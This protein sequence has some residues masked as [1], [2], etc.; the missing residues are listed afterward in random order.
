MKDCSLRPT[1]HHRLRPQRTVVFEI[2]VHGK[3][4]G[5]G[6]HDSPMVAQQ[7]ASKAALAH[8]E[9]IEGEE[10][11]GKNDGGDG[12]VSCGG[13]DGDCGGNDKDKGKETNKE[14]KKVRICDCVRDMTMLEGIKEFKASLLERLAEEEGT[15][16][17]VVEEE[18]LVTTTTETATKTLATS[19]TSALEVELE[20]EL[21]VSSVNGEGEGT[22]ETPVSTTTA[23]T[24]SWEEM[25]RSVSA[26]S[27][28]TTVSTSSSSSSSPSVSKRKLEGESMERSECG[29]RQAGCQC[30]VEE[31]M[32]LVGATGT[33][34]LGA[35]ECD[36][37][38]A[39]GA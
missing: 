5:S 4:I 8:I 6:E 1:S 35:E 38:S 18:V 32:A 34:A 25:E 22:R 21:E 23:S 39:A 31:D 16:D 29:K 15:G 13:G 17:G 20:Q 19:T 12:G 36:C 27:N 14:K 7:L 33:L 2:R 11:S 3:V 37:C 26:Q 9:A 24:T 10:E 30:A 28:D